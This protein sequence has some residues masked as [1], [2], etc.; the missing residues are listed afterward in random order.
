MSPSISSS[1]LFS[2]AFPYS[3]PIDWRESP[4]RSFTIAQM[5]MA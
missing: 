5:L 3:S 2:S 1:R 4:I